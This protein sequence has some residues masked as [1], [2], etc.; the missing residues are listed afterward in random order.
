MGIRREGKIY[1]WRILLKNHCECDICIQQFRQQKYQ[2]KAVCN[3]QAILCEEEARSM[4]TKL[5]SRTQENYQFL[6]EQWEVGGSTISKRLKKKSSE[7]RKALLMEVDPDMY[8]HPWSDLRFTQTFLELPAMQ[9]SE[10]GV[11]NTDMELT[12]GE[13]RWKYR[14]VCLLPYIDLECLKNDPDSLL[15]VLYNRIKYSPQHWAPFDN[16]TIDK[17]WNLG[18]LQLLYN[19]NCIVMHGAGYGKLTLGQRFSPC[20]GHRRFSEGNTRSGSP[21]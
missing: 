8:P 7:K 4:A 18:A 9:A 20:L 19:R 16:Y 6:R 17:S 1:C 14:D 15:S 5:V 13:M 12:Q 10:S 21:K 3:Y 11:P 2:T